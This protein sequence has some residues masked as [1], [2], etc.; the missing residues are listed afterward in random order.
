MKKKLLIIL[1]V[2][3]VVELGVFAY[4][5]IFKNDKAKN[6]KL[7]VVEKDLYYQKKKVNIYLFWGDG[8]PHCEA[9]LKYL[10][11]LVSKYGKYFNIFALEVWHNENNAKLY[12]KLA[13]KMG[14]EVKGVPYTIIGEKTFSGYSEEI[15]KEIIKTIKSQYKD[16]YDVYFDEE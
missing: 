13:E 8:C 16:S 6:I 9:E 10:D 12:E 2:I 5:K 1:C 3:L 14:D 7:D 4:W 15:N 11:S